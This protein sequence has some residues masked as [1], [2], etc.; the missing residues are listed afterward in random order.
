MNKQMLSLAIVCIILLSTS[1][2]FAG[3]TIPADDLTP[4]V[5]SKGINNPKVSI[6][7]R[8]KGGASPHG[9]D[10]PGEG[11]IIHSPGDLVERP[12]GG[13]GPHG[14]DTIGQN[15]HINAAHGH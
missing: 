4:V 11:K 1:P 14:G 3:T 7:R 10:A 9:F 6:E 12:K 2:S 5:S 8:P 15:Q 13:P